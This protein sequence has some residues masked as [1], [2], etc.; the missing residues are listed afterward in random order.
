M[1]SFRLAKDPAER[2]IAEKDSQ[3][4]RLMEHHDRE[5]ETIRAAAEVQI[6]AALRMRD[7]EVKA[8]DVLIAVL[9]ARLKDVE[10]RFYASVDRLLVKEGRV[11]PVSPSPQLQEDLDKKAARDAMTDVDRLIAEVN[12]A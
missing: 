9:E 6:Q 11:L 3:I 5:R 8:K 2:M 1:F 12:V 4:R 7:T 10:S